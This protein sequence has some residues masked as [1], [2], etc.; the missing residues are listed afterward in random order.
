MGDHCPQNH[1]FV[2]DG[3]ALVMRG[4]RPAQPFGFIIL[5]GCAGQTRSLCGARSVPSRG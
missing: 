4:D 5:N 1:G 3:Q 2:A